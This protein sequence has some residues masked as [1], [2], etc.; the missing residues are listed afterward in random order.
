MN[1]QYGLDE[2]WPKS[3]ALYPLYRSQTFISGTIYKRMPNTFGNDC[4]IKNYIDTF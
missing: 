3:D 1:Q 4:V 2:S